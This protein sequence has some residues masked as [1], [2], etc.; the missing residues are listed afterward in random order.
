M[1]P[2][3]ESGFILYG[4]YTSGGIECESHGIKFLLFSQTWNAVF[5]LSCGDGGVS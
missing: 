5:D 1:R 2:S 4:I 3:R